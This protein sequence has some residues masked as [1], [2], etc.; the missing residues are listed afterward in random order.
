MHSNSEIVVVVE[1]AKFHLYSTWCV[2]QSFK[3]FLKPVCILFR[4]AI[5]TYCRFPKLKSIYIYI[6]VLWFLA[7]KYSI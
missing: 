6:Y 1:S 3:K 4:A 2:E 7:V 5:S